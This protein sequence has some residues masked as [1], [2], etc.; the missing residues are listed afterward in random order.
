M[1]TVSS[2]VTTVLLLLG[3]VFVL[4]QN[5]K[6][7]WAQRFGTTGGSSTDVAYN[8]ATD[9]AGNVIVVGDNGGILV[10]K[11]SSAGEA[12]WTNHYNF[13]GSDHAAAVAVDGN[14]NIFV[15]G[16]AYPRCVTLAISSS[17]VSL[18][19][20]QF[21][22]P[23][24]FGERAIALALD[25]GGNVF[26]LGQTGGANGYGDYFTL[27]YSNNGAA[28]WTNRFDGGGLDTA[29]ALATD[30]TG[31]VVVTG[32][33]RVTG[34]D[35]DVITIKYA[36]NGAPLWTN[37][38]SGA[39]PDY[40]VPRSLV[41]DE[42]GNVLIAVGSYGV[43]ELILKLSSAG[44]RLWTN[45]A[46]A[47]VASMAVDPIENVLM[48]GISYLSN[49]DFD[50]ACITTI[51]YSPNGAIIW[52]NQELLAWEDL[53]NVGMA[54]GGDETVFVTG[55]LDEG[56]TQVTLK[57]SP[58]GSTLWTNFYATGVDP[59]D[60]DPFSTPRL[61][62]DQNG[63]AFVMGVSSSD[64]VTLK[65][66]G[67]GEA[68]W[69]NVYNGRRPG[70]GRPSA[71]A[72]DPSG[73]IVVTGGGLDFATVKYSS[74]GIPL[75]IN[76][77]DGP[78]HFGDKA[79][80]V[81]VASN[82]NIFVTGYSYPGD[83]EDV[84]P[85]YMT[86]AYSGAGVPLWTNACFS[87]GI[88]VAIVVDGNGD[89]VVTGN[90]DVVLGDGMWVTIKYSGAGVPLW[91]NRNNS[92]TSW[93]GDLAV[94]GHG[95]LIVVGQSAQQ[96]FATVKY[97]SSGLGMW[98]NFYTCNP[99]NAWGPNGFAT[100]VAVWTNGDIFVTGYNI[101]PYDRDNYDDGSQ[102]DFVTIK[103][104]AAG[105]PVWTNHYG[106]QGIGDFAQA[107]AVD[108]SGNVVVTGVSQNNA[109]N[110]AQTIVTIKYSNGGVARWTNLCVA[111]SRPNQPYAGAV[112]FNGNVFVTGASSY[113]GGSDSITL[114]YSSGGIPLW[115][116]RYNGPPGHN[117]AG[118]D[119]AVMGVG[120]VVV[121]GASS[122][123]YATIKYD[124]SFALN[125][126]SPPTNRLVTVGTTVTFSVE[127]SG[128][129]P[130]TFQWQRNGTNLVNG[131]NVSGATTSNL[132]LAMVTPGDAGSYTVV[133]SNPAG[134]VTSAV[135]V[136][137]VPIFQN[138]TAALA[139]GMP[140]G[141]ST[142]AWGDYD[143]D[144]RL[145]LFVGGFTTDDE[146]EDMW[147]AQ[148]WRN[149]DSGF[150]NVT[151]TVAADRIGA[152][153]G[154]A[155]WGD[156]DND[157]RLDLIFTGQAGIE[158]ETT[159]IWRNTGTGFVNVSVLNLTNVES[160]FVTWGDF[161]NDGRL[162]F[163][164][165]GF[166][167][168]VNEN[169]VTVPT[170]L[171]RNTG[172]GFTNVTVTVTPGLPHVHRGAVAWADYDND[173]RLD[174]LI[175]GEHFPSQGPV[176]Q[177]W[178]NTEAGFTNVTAGVAP[179]LPQLLASSV[180]WGDYDNDGRLDFLITGTTNASN[181]QPISQLWRNTGNTFTN[182]TTALAVGVP[183]VYAGS[184]AWGDY[185][186]D[187]RLDFLIAGRTN[188]LNASQISQ[189]WRNMGNG[190]TNVTASA[191]LPQSSTAAW[192][193]FDNDGRLDLFFTGFPVGFWR[194]KTTVTNTPPGAPTGLA[195]TASSN[196]VMLSW[197]SATDDHTPAG[198]LT[199]NVRA[200][201]R[202]GG[203]DLLS[204]HV[205]ATNG[206]RRV[207]A[208]GNA[209]LSHS[210]TLTGITNGQTVYWS[211]QA[212]DT[213]F[214]GGSFATETSVVSL[215]RLHITRSSATNPVVSWTP[216][217]LGWV[218]QQSATV[219]A[220]NWTIAASG[221]ANPATLS[222]TNGAQFYRL[223]AP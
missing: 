191:G 6:Q 175:T 27:K 177:L 39:Q 152:D 153:G 2:F 113:A 60:G 186:N 207:P 52:T 93:A 201:T 69:T 31:N 78:A 156:F 166:R 206:F 80:A 196:A 164:I 36:G 170:Q 46:P 222:P 137:S 71:V 1:N 96:T 143:N 91:T 4:A 120:Q 223:S 25:N 90:D 14:G 47:S 115:T 70:D 21:G 53:S 147:Y 5:D 185:D 19:T 214:A 135:A 123:D 180:A 121:V 17:G 61:V 160:S 58:A 157:G 130:I 9:S 114:A 83:W 204:G 54:I 145:D 124:S 63:N 193:D 35:S 149:T 40:D 79:T 82:G 197:N 74:A 211:V 140:Y 178:R 146:G 162:D 190:F 99:S 198:G 105:V 22:I 221:S 24:S 94:D 15:T 59:N 117:D 209:M 64:F 42:N 194:N 172:S 163:L 107:L 81:A 48:S 26:V 28:L 30:N 45:R 183:D 29:I 89:V 215:P 110:Y 43:G 77:Y 76:Y 219:N 38:Y 95:D 154:S 179:G 195:M 32:E 133:I 10:V 189:L 158:S 72:V 87:A 98:T 7:V 216:P 200:G 57:Y 131:G 108:S 217:T 75:W 126:T 202:H 49:E 128:T 101:D 138:V 67:P 73:D 88:P 213:S 111:T 151:D 132:T 41:V 3:Q 119:L 50:G 12:L 159:Q 65:Y 171:W 104:S 127:G 109:A 37:R 18:W 203:N 68:I 92:I 199:Y 103:Y 51:K 56:A 192:V 34:S 141:C 161:D 139:T 118:Y 144:G 174:F 122:G 86:V 112:D 55:L 84:S 155:A 142:M 20:N 176:S 66:S 210:L 208:M 182:V 11:Y 212:V 97:S 188:Y 134:S 13:S 173:G 23:P 167:Y 102:Y 136:L 116:N 33:A 150:T 125:I 16:A 44:A 129:A 220:S 106:A 184:V 8:L 181:P 85:H 148:I 205:N 169:E 187:G 165:M 218:L 168:D 62:I 100:A